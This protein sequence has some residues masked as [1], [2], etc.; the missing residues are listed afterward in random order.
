MP[1]RLARPFVLLAAA[2]SL[3]VIAAGCGQDTVSPDDNVVAGKKLFVA[4][5]GACH[6]LARAATKGTVGPDL[7]AAFRQ[8]IADGQ[9]RTVV[10]GVVYAQIL[11]P[12]SLRDHSTG[13]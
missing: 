7:D 8:A 11:H 1:K 5:C 4:K 2:A 13:L 3:V 12:A 9:G 6:T 10:K